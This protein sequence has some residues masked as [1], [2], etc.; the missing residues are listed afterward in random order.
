MQSV[1][2]MKFGEERAPNT[3]DWLNGTKDTLIWCKVRYY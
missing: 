3:T 2:G 1:N